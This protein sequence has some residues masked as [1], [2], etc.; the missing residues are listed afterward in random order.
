MIQ[1]GS[2]A[3]VSKDWQFGIFGN[4]KQF[5]EK[6]LKPEYLRCISILKIGSEE[7]YLC[8]LRKPANLVSEH[9][10]ST[11]GERL[12]CGLFIGHEGMRRTR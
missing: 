2:E 4:L 10:R 6:A 5:S 9:P 12:S 3:H 7:F 1:T 11:N 8:A